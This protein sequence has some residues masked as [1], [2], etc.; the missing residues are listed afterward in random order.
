LE[1]QIDQI[2]NQLI[3]LTYKISITIDKKNITC[4][5]ILHCNIIHFI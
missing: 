2:I 4:K 3:L 1:Y 5:T